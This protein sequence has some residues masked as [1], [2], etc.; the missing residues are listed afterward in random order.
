MNRIRIRTFYQA[1]PL[2]L[3]PWTDTFI[4]GLVKWAPEDLEFSLVGMTTDALARPV[5]RW[6][7][8]S[9][10]LVLFDFFPVF[11]EPNPGGKARV[12]WSL[13]LCWHS[14]R[15]REAVINCFD[16]LELHRVEPLILFPPRPKNA[17][18]HQDMSI[19]RNR[20]ADIRWKGLPGAYFLLEDFVVPMLDSAYCVREAAV[21]TLRGRFPKFAPN[22]N[23]V[24]TWVDTEVFHPE[25]QGDTARARSDLRVRLG[26]ANET[27]LIV[28]VGR[29]DTQKNPQLLL[30]AFERVASARDNAA[31]VFIGD[32]LL[33]AEMEAATKARGLS[34]RVH[35]LG[36]RAPTEV[37]SILR[38]AD[39][40]ALSSAYEGMPMALMEALGSGLP[41]V[42]TDVGE[43]R[44]VVSD[45]CGLVV[46]R[47]EP[48]LF[49]QA[50][51][52]VLERH[53]MLAG[54]PCVRAIE[55]YRPGT[56][57]GPIY[58]NYRRLGAKRRVGALATA[59]N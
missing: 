42:T 30:S 49:A 6:T 16:V 11:H 40:F 31:L 59:D 47:Q 7:R 20:N 46:E 24:P 55:H 58:Q 21:A 33:R 18:F 14:M 50:L 25:S 1:D 41:V 35:F 54:A 53:A 48:E 12:P 57:L 34:A 8:C 15:H 17:F 27:M 29:M 38:S 37:A 3:C 26:C 51:Q 36:L 5:G 43:V 45:E 2:V 13:Q 39:V 52:S 44:K 56:V 19:L 22:I 32:G 10:G 23:F 9:L 4:C 28:T